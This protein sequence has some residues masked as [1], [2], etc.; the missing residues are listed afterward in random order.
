[1][2]FDF[3]NALL[4]GLLIALTCWFVGKLGPLKGKSLD[5]K[6]L[7]LAPACFVVVL[8]FNVLWSARG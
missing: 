2:G 4:T 5:K 7:I 6:M 1:M 8:V 3:W